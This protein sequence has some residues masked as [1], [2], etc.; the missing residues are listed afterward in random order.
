MNLGIKNPICISHYYSTVTAARERAFSDVLRNWGFPDPEKR[1]Y[2]LQLPGQRIG[3][4]NYD[5]I[6]EI[7]LRDNTVDGVFAMYIETLYAILEVQKNDESLKQRHLKFVTVGFTNALFHNKDVL[8]T[9]SQPAYEM[10]R[11]AG[12]LLTAKIMKWNNVDFTAHIDSRIEKNM[13]D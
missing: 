5:E 13:A 12:E 3:T 6:K 4:E 1:I 2:R 7:L 10:G 8:Y 11:L 9:I